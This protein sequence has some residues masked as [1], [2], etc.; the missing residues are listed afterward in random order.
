MATNAESVSDSL[1]ESFDNILAAGETLPIE[2]LKKRYEG[3]EHFK[4]SYHQAAIFREVMDLP[5]TVDMLVGDEWE[6]VRSI[7][8]SLRKLHGDG[9]MFRFEGYSKHS[10][11]AYV[12]RD[13]EALRKA[14]PA[15][16]EAEYK[17][18]NLDMAKDEV[19]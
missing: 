1:L 18:A 5:V 2:Q 16:A 6:A 11:I 3:S 17:T 15:F 10:L 9:L 19:A 14:W 7:I 8:T 4:S 12:W 13:E